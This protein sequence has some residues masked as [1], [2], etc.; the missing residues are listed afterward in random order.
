M[1]LHLFV[2]SLSVRD[3]TVALFGAVMASTAAWVS[4]LARQDAHGAAMGILS[5]IIDVGRPTGPIWWVV[6]WLGALGYGTAFGN[7]A[8]SMQP[9]PLR[10]FSLRSVQ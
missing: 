7:V 1:T 10:V 2:R 8:A 4:D 6:C 5:S 3:S 9:S